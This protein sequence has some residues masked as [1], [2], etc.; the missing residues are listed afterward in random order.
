MFIK[1]TLRN[2]KSIWLNVFKVESIV[3]QEIY[4]NVMFRGDDYPVEVKESPEQI[5]EMIKEMKKWN[6]I[7]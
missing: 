3:D 6:F 4:S 7:K 1:L 5:I 2:D